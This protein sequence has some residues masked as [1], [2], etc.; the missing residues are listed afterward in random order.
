MCGN[1][2][3][4]EGE[5]CDCGTIEVRRKFFSKKV[6]VVRSIDRIQ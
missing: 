2:F 5:E 4:E 3:K 1:G 6:L